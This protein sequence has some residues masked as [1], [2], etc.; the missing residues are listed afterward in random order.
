MAMARVSGLSG[1]LLSIALLLNSCASTP[2]LP[3][4]VR[5]QTYLPSLAGLAEPPLWPA[6]ASRGYSRRIRLILIPTLRRRLSIRLDTRLSGQSVGHI[7]R[8]A[9]DQETHDWVDTDDRAFSINQA[10]LA[11]LDGLIAGSKI[12]NLYPEF[13]QAPKDSICIDGVEIVLER[14]TPAGY[15]YSEANAQCTAP[16]SMLKI[17]GQMVAM[18]G[19]ANSD[20]EG[21]LR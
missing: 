13:W 12:W 8:Q 3:P 6:G 5:G 7:V 9:Y 21:W 1:A 17:A 16:Q 4:D 2:A 15:R 10:D 11:T 18:A 20:V 19:L 14:A